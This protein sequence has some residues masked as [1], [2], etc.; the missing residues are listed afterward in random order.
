LLSPRTT[1]RKQPQKHG[2]GA[3]PVQRNS[4][5]GKTVDDV[6]SSQLKPLLSSSH[7]G[8]VVPQPLVDV[9][10]IEDHIL[11][12]SID[13]DNNSKLLRSKENN[14][15]IVVVRGSNYVLEL[16]PRQLGIAAAVFN[17][18]WGGLNL[19]P[20]HY[21]ARQDPRLK[22]AGYLIS[23]A[24]GGML[25]NV[26]LWLIWYLY[27]L[28]AVVMTSMRQSS[29]SQQQQPQ[30]RRGATTT[31]TAAAMITN[32]KT[33]LREA[34][35][36]LPSLQIRAWGLRGGLAGLLYSIGNVSS[37][38]A[39]AA[40]GQST[41]FSA[42]MMQLFVSGLWGTFYFGEIRG[43]IWAVLP[44]FASAA[45]AVTG[46]VGLSYQHIDEGAAAAAARG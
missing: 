41:G 31:M 46:I 23:Y 26:A 40:L 18:A 32:V 3:A 9:E 17:G 39:V 45:L 42:C 27:E 37:I 2:S 19:I 11:D 43:G 29:L 25:V 34:G 35:E 15:I 12:D 13:K 10:I 33:I 28:V 21:A 20:L 22:G 5:F 24:T 6:S 16:T 14:I 4:S 7:G 44:W 30:H 36:A 1:N 8:V 38:L